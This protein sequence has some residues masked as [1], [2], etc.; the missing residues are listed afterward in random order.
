[1]RKN[2]LLWKSPHDFHDVQYVVLAS[3]TSSMCAL[4]SF[5]PW[6]TINKSLKLIT[7]KWL[8]PKY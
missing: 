3:F 7:Q 4:D 6:L 5:I 2:G 1:L 8:I